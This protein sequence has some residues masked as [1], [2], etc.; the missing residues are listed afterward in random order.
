MLQTED[1]FLASLGLLRGGRLA[2]V[3][4]QAIN[5]RRLAFF[6][7]VGPGMDQVEIEYRQGRS[8]VDLRL[9]KSEVA[10]LKDIAFAELRK[11]RRNGG[12]D[13]GRDRAAEGS[14]PNRGRAW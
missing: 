14:Q 2:S 12:S 9:L 11:E 6:R 1:I 3:E 8:L 4:V 7:I 13:G 10:R 5:N